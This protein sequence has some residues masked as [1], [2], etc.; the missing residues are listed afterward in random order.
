MYSIRIKKEK[1]G[2]PPHQPTQDIQHSLSGEKLLAT[3]DL[4]THQRR[5]DTIFAG[6]VMCVETCDY[7]V[8]L[9]PYPM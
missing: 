2:D 4:G 1:K 8:S 7:K 3:V 6:H 9:W 5:L